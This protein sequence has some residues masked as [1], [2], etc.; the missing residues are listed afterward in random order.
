MNFKSSLVLFLFSIIFINCFADSCTKSA[1]PDYYHR[2]MVT[3]G[4]SITY[5]DYGEFL[6]CMLDNQGIGYDFIGSK[7][8][9][10]GFRHE[11]YGGY[12]TQNIIDLRLK[13]ISSADAYFI[14]LGTNDINFTPMQ[15]V[16]NLMTIGIYLH[17]KNPNAI[18][19]MS[20][21]LPRYKPYHERNIQ[22]NDILKSNKWGNNIQILDVGGDFLAQPNWKSYLLPD[23]LHPNYAG[24]SIITWSIIKNI[25]N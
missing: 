11:G 8:D 23:V 16:S 19:Y 18:I 4:D 10:F 13:E 22:V 21:L 24:Y 5:A 20:T 2:T 15:T 7:I 6:R 1:K 9:K 17:T 25:Y 12:N 3:L 14:L